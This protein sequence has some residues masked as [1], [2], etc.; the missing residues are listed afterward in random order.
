M[1]AQGTNSSYAIYYRYDG[2]YLSS[3]RS[4]IVHHKYCA[5][6]RETKQTNT[7]CMYT[8][9]QTHQISIYNNIIF[10]CDCNLTKWSYFIIEFFFVPFFVCFLGAHIENWMRYIR[11]RVFVLL[12]VIFC[13]CFSIPLALRSRPLPLFLFEEPETI[14]SIDQI[15]RPVGTGSVCD[16]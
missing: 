16:R 15:E 13:V 10:S 2:I 12:L 5:E 4:D 14:Q 7:K 11:I 8:A 3:I 9:H 6:R 1:T